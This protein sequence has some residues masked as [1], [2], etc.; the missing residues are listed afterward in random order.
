[1]VYEKMH[2]LMMARANK[3]DIISTE[4]GVDME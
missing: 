2:L 4:A 3:Y 1:M